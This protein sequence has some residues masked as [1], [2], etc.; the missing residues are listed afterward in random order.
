[1]RSILVLL[2]ISLS[3]FAK[4][5][6]VGTYNVENLFDGQ[7]Q[8]S[9]YKDFKIGRN[10]WSKKMADIKFSHT[11]KAIKLINADVLA[12][13][14]VENASLIKRLAKEGGFSYFAFTKPHKSPVGVGILSKYPIISKKSI[15]AGIERTRDFLHVNIHIDG[16]NLGIWI[17]HFPTQKYP[18]KKRQKVA[19]TLKRAIQKSNDKEF[20]MVGDF[21]TKISS[22][23]ILQKSFG[24]LSKRAD[25]YDTWFS[26]PYAN[27]YSQVFYGKKSALDRMIISK[28]LY[29]G[30]GL[31]YKKNSFGVVKKSFLKDSRGY[32]NRWKMKKRYHQGDGYSDH[33]PLVLTITTNGVVKSD[34]K[35]LPISKLYSLDGKVDV[36][37]KQAVVTYKNKSG[38]IITQKDGRGIFVYKP[39]FELKKGFMYDFAVQEVKSY[40]GIKEVT[41]LHVKKEHGKVRDLS[42]YFVDELKSAKVN[43]VIKSISGKVKGR[44][45]VSS[46]GKI[47][48]FWKDKKEISDGERLNLKEV[49]VGKYKGKLELILEERE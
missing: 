7:N 42:S 41:L 13:Q 30:V 40:K 32:P 25:F 11:L 43:D 19:D 14:E 10:G 21:N 1:M 6:R 36:S 38:Y 23:S 26:I 48:L 5:V 47:K 22:N 49:R 12:L 17:V 8:G 28:G 15:Y 35:T 4:D 44:Y 20:L 31:E 27:R 18:I 9:E 24:N 3:L 29:D 16:K 34:S 46:Q 2:C 39:G 45:L 33:F 37:I